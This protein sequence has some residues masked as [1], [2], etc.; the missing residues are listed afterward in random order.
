MGPSGLPGS[1]V[2]RVNTRSY[3]C[4]VAWQKRAGGA[5]VPREGKSQRCVTRNSGVPSASCISSSSC[6]SSRAWTPSSLCSPSSRAKERMSGPGGQML[7]AVQDTSWS[8]PGTRDSGDTTSSS[9]KA[10]DGWWD[11][12]LSLEVRA[13][14]G[15][16]GFVVIVQLCALGGQE[17]WIG[18][19][20]GLGCGGGSEVWG[21]VG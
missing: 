12:G 11:P 5:G 1:S 10:V 6:S 4:M 2:L 3:S 9:G 15:R 21:P 19:L 8:C 17:G 14:P 7:W 16:S 20:E 13:E 18:S